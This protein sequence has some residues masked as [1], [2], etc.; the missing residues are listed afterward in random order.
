MLGARAYWALKVSSFFFL[1]CAIM[2]T[3]AINAIKNTPPAAAAMI[4]SVVLRDELDPR[5]EL[6]L[7]EEEDDDLGVECDVLFRLTDAPCPKVV[8]WEE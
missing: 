8:F 1:L 7:T 4:V 2:S 3:R 6:E 5:E